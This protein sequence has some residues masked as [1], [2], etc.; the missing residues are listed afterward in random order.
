M[1]NEYL[2]WRVIC[3]EILIV[4]Y[5]LFILWNRIIA[6]TAPRMTAA[7]TFDAEPAAFENTV[8]ENRF[9]HVLAACRC[10]TASRRCQRRNE[11]PIEINPLYWMPIPELNK[12]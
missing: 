7:D 6:G 1:N 5:S 2:A 11:N 4:N 12:G 9:Y 8:F 3:Y 10:I